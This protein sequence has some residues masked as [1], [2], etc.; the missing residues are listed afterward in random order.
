[1][2]FAVPVDAE[3]SQCVCVASYVWL[4]SWSMSRIIFPYLGL[5]KSVPIYAL[6]AEEAT[7]LFVVHRE[8]M[9]PFIFMG[10]SSTGC[11]PR[12]KWQEFFLLVLDTDK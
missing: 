9:A 4:S 7:K 8:N 12:K 6:A 11:H 3:L 5:T 1:M 10:Q 2:P